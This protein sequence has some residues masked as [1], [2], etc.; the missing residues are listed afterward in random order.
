MREDLRCDS[1]KF[2]E[3][4]DD[5]VIEVKCSSKFCGASAGLV[6]LHRFDLRTGKLMETLRFREPDRE[7]H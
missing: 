7:K 4:L 3:L 6:I 2:G 5:S 1:K